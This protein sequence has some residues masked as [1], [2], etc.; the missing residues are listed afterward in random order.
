MITQLRS[1]PLPVVAP[2]CKLID[3]EHI[4]GDL[5]GRMI[6]VALAIYLLPALFVVLAVGGVG[7]L[8]LSLNRILR[9]PVGR[10]VG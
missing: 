8:I 2:E 3:K 4:H 10:P 1:V 9:S 6:K 5:A 7:M